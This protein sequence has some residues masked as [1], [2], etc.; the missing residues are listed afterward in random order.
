MRINTNMNM[1]NEFQYIYDKLCDEESKDIFSLRQMYLMTNDYRF[2][3]EMIKKYNH[4]MYLNSAKIIESFWRET[5]S[6]SKIIIYGAGGTLKK[7]MYYLSELEE[8]LDKIRFICDEN[9]DKQGGKFMGIPII[10][11]VD[12]KLDDDTCI[13]VCSDIYGDK[14]IKKYKSKFGSRLLFLPEEHFI[15][16]SEEQYF[17]EEIIAYDEDEIFIDA[18]AC[19]LESSCCLLARCN[20]VKKIYAFE[21]DQA[22]IEKCEKK[23]L[24]RQLDIVKIIPCAAYKENTTLEFCAVDT[25]WES[26]INAENGM[27]TY[28]VNAQ[29]IDDT[30]PL[31]EN[32]TFIKM[33]IEGAELD[34][35]KGA[36]HTI[37]RC[38]P[39]L[40]ICMYH[41]P[42][43][44]MELPLF[45]LKLVPEY[46]LFVRHYTN[47][48]GETV[49]YAI[50]GD[51]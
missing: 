33:D 1:Y 5:D 3:G 29:T 2:I 4:R 40:A 6:Y 51:Q 49:L 25:G 18:G 27:S 44:M 10:S 42:E 35:L 43:D 38:K 16:Y 48:P 14:I 46:K 11:P 21:P 12:M 39:K 45:I 8:S 37:K 17:D 23:K 26:H 47:E 36:E 20:T 41:K 22:N 28:A 7:Y 24:N 30:I 19:G 34:A 13:V 9:P 32:V 50:M 15:Q 31:E